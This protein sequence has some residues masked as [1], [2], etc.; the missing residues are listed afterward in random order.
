MGNYHPGPFWLSLELTKKDAPAVGPL[1]IA[2]F[3][4]YGSHHSSSK[5]IGKDLTFEP[6]SVK[7]AGASS[8]LAAAVG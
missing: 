1:K 7:G 2:G 3:F 6:L 8:R 4:W 5:G